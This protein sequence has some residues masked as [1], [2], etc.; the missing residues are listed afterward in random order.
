MNLRAAQCDQSLWYH[1]GLSFD[2][3]DFRSGQ[4]STSGGQKWR[5][6]IATC[7]DT[8]QRQ[9][10]VMRETAGRDAHNQSLCREAPHEP[11]KH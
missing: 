7:R 5:A 3:C 1:D 6:V 11:T 2:Q 9:Q 4:R 8:G 10:A